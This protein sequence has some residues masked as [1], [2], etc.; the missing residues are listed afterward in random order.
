MITLVQIELLRRIRCDDADERLRD[1]FV[2]TANGVS[3]GMRNG[4]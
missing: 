1:A 3:A 2:L 4:G